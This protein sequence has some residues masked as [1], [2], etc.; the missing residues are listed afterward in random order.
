MFPVHLNYMVHLFHFYN[1][2]SQDFKTAIWFILLIL[3]K[4]ERKKETGTS[5]L[6]MCSLRCRSCGPSFFAA[7]T[8][9]QFSTLLTF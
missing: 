3:F 9:P 7:L 8:L 4:P 5:M 1:L 2:S 6:M